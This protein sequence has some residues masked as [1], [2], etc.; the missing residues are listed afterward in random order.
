[1]TGPSK[2]EP[3]EPRS[4]SDRGPTLQRDEVLLATVLRGGVLLSALLIAVGTFLHLVRGGTPPSSYRVFSRSS[5]NLS[6][7]QA[8]VHGVASLGGRPLIE[9][10][11]LVLIATPILRVALSVGL[12]AQERDVTYVVVTVIVF[13]ALLFSLIG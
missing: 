1:M 7:L 10:G 12:F 9:L 2:G 4:T 5:F 6:N 8:M 13:G 3:R 11:L